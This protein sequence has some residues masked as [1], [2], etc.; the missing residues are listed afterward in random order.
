VAPNKDLAERVELTLA[1]AVEFLLETRDRQGHWKDVRSTAAAAWAL[2][3]VVKGRN[4]PPDH[5]PFLQSVVSD[6]ATWLAGQAKQ[7]EGGVSWESEAWDTSCAILALL[8]AG[9]YEDRVDRA[10]AWLESIRCKR[11]GVWYD[12]IWETVLATVALLR[13]EVSRRGP[14]REIDSLVTGIMRWL[15]EIPSKPSGEFVS[16]HYSAFLVWLDSELHNGSIRQ[17]TFRTTEYLE[18]RAKVEAS[19]RWL[20]EYALINDEMLWCPYTFSNAYI[21]FALAQHPEFRRTDD[22]FLGPV[23]NWLREQQGRSG[24]FEDTEDTSLGILALSTIHD[25]LESRGEALASRLAAVRAMSDSHRIPCFIGYAGK[26]RSIALELKDF[27]G[28]NAPRLQLIDWV[29]DFS[30]GNTIIDEL[31]AKSRECKLALFIVTRD[32]QATIGESVHTPRDNVV[33]EVGF[34]SGR[35]GRDRTIMIVEE[36]TSLPSDWGGVIYISMKDRENLAS[37]HTPLLRSL[38]RIVELPRHTI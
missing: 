34:F 4:A 27:L 31:E 5:L 1:A 12:E 21:A 17:S 11:S 33:F 9:A 25:L 6:A 22:A 30:T 23:I 15:L 14:R 19:A 32:E 16:P 10:A 2:S 28:N 13:R 8:A 18:F 36:G 3:H 26:S 24:G 20:V 38:N 7:E 37:I 29:W 35:L